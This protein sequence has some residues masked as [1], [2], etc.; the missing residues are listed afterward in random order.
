M[1]LTSTTTQCDSSNIA[2]IINEQSEHTIDI[3]SGNSDNS[4]NS[5]TDEVIL[6]SEPSD[7]E[8][9]F[10][11]TRK[12]RYKKL[13]FNDV[14]SKINEHYE[15]DTVHRYSS[16]MDILAS[17][18]KGQKII[19]MESRTHT[20]QIL[21]M[22]MLPSI[23]LTGLT[24]V[25]Q[26]QLSQFTD[27]SAFILACMNAFIAFILAIINYLKYDATSEAHKIS[28]HQY[29]K[30]QSYVEF[31]SGQILL[32]SDPLLS[33]LTSKRQLEEYSDTLH[34]NEEYEFESDKHIHEK[35]VNI[36]EIV[37][38][39]SQDISNSQTSIL[40]TNQKLSIYNKLILNKKR[41][42]FDKKQHE[43]LALINDLKIKISKIE[44]KIADIKETNQ[45]IIPRCVR[46]RYPLIYHTNIFSIIKKI[47]DYKIETITN[48]KH[49][50]NEIRFINALQKKHNYKLSNKFNIKLKHLFGQKKEMV[51]T[52]LYLNTAFSVIDRMFLREIAN[53]ELKKKHALRF[54]VNSIFTM[55]APTFCKRWF[56]PRKYI[57]IHE[58]GG[59]LLQKIMDF[60]KTNCQ[61]RKK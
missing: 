24:S 20:V 31:Q 46:Y 50:K 52:I 22:L 47:D 25:G 32:F 27:K 39:S 5:D 17:Y 7:T 44:E 3:N 59:L 51:N 15:Q 26:E 35:L 14:L 61:R 54:F 53:A 4:D 1:E 30:L 10:S 21:N 28:S 45:F 41:E 49:I 43:K 12:I 11:S 40:T 60:P 29:D 55:F 56:L 36:N 58:S 9:D 42:I 8:S 18:L 37:D 2:L 6:G 34:H 23:F 38:L 57:P 33:K 19:Y 48:L 13:T 16:A